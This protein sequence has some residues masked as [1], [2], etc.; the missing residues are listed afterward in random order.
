MKIGSS[1]SVKHKTSELSQIQTL[2]TIFMS[3]YYH[4]YAIT[5][6]E[7]DYFWSAYTLHS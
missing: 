4:Y 5:I 7:T 3:S 2:R 1:S 6:N